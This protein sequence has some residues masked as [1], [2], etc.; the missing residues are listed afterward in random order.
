MKMATFKHVSY[1]DDEFLSTVALL[2]L[3]VFIIL[4]CVWNV[5]NV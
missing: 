4:K 5:Y 1:G 3:N 2:K